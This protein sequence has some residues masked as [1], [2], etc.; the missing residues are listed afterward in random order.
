[1]SAPTTSDTGPAD[2]DTDE[3][4]PGWWSASP[5]WAKAFIAGGLALLLVL[6]GVI[7]GIAIGRSTATTY[8]PAADSIDV[9]FLQDMV[10]HHNQGVEMAVWARNNTADPEI[11]Q[12][13][14]DI[15][16][17]QTSQTGRMEGW[18]TLWGDPLTPPSGQFMGW[19]GMPA[20]AMPGMA[21]PQDLA[22][23]RASTGREMDVVFLQLMLRH[24]Q[25]G[26]PMM[27][28]AAAEASVPA[29]AALAQSMVTSQSS[30]VGVMTQMLAARGAAPL[31][32]PEM[33]GGTSMPGMN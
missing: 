6:V 19:M 9:G 16:S 2:L 18:L 31:P 15:E 25:G 28:T 30:E 22:R 23:L 33:H 10:V 26:L 1:M 14:Y 21:S 24:H 8:G 11:R 3:G 12:I 32:A 5:T 7:G 29:V 4:R 17:T 13:A 20:A 27:Q